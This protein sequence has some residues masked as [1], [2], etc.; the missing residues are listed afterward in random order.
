LERVN[1]QIRRLAVSDDEL[2]MTVEKELVWD[3]KVDDQAIV[4]GVED[5]AVTLRG[6]VGSFRERREAA[7]AAKRVAGV[8][9]LHDR[10]KVRILDTQRRDDAD[11]RGAVLQAL[12]LDS[13]V[14]STINASARDGVVTLK[15]LG[16][17]Q[18]P[19]R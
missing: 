12:G 5:G 18:L 13:V 14:P 4:V 15:G 8:K 17:V 6:T 10:L 9:A 7:R 1:A 2:R 19:A 3:P 16:S 11:L